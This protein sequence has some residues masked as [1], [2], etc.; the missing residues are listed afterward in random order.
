MLEDDA[1][2][3]RWMKPAPGQFR[4]EY[5]SGKTYEPDFVVET[6]DA[7]LLLEPK[8]ADE[9]HAEDVQLK[10]KAARQ[11]CAYANQHAAR[12]QGKPWEYRLLAHAA[13]MLGRSLAGLRAL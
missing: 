2:V 7:C 6:Q 1:E 13:I 8:R 3:L 10:A 9:L 4:I 12:N 5:H 11:W